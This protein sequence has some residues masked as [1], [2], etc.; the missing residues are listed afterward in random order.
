MV[1]NESA[2]LKIAAAGFAAVGF[3][4]TFMQSL[5]GAGD[6]TPT[7]IMSVASAWLIALPLAFFLPQITNLGVYGVR[8]GIAAGLICNGIAQTI[9][10][11]F[12]RWKRKNV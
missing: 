6:T 9:Y 8:W 4:A 5:N 12:G 3:M 11:S 7:M 10:F 1:F 2:F